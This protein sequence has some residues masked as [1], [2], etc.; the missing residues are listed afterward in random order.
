MG[1]PPRVSGG[2]VIRLA[3]GWRG[4]GD[5][6]RCRQ[7]PARLFAMTARNIAS[8]AGPLIASLRWIWTARAVALP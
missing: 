8:K 3:T 4:W 1:Q 6:L 5:A 7:P 2:S